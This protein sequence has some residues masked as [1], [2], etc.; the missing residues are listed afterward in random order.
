MGVA[1]SL[2]LLVPALDRRW[3]RKRFDACTR[4]LKPIT[5]YLSHLETRFSARYIMHVAM[6]LQVEVKSTQDIFARNA[7]LID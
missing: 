5:S 2:P 1:D 3:R 6:Q 4:N 7:M